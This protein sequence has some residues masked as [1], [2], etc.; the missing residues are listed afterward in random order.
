M[1][2]GGGDTGGDGDSNLRVINAREVASACRLVLFGL[3]RERVRVHTGVGATR[4]MVVRLDLVEVFALLLLET[5]LAVEDELEGG[6]GA[7][8]ILGVS[9]TGMDAS[10]DREEGRTE[11]GEGNVAVGEGG[12]GLRLE[13]DISIGGDVGEVPE[14]VLVGGN[15]GEAPHQFLDG[16]IVREAD[17]LGGTLGHSVNTSVLN[18]LNEV[19]VT[20]LG[21]SPTLLSV[22]VHVISV[23]LEGGSGIAAEIGS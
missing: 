21:K 16:V 7:V 17:L 1:H 3:E 6:E 18:L 2:G 4:V 9:G 22:E 14:R 12:G 23:N 10:A 15:V 13:N 20:L 19:L 8:G 5:V 11:R